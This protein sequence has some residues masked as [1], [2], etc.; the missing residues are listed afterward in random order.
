M[1]DKSLFPC[2]KCGHQQ[3]DHSKYFPNCYTCLDNKKQSY[4]EFERIPNLEFL[5]WIDKQKEKAR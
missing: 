4:C 5:E 1:V 2:H 3:N